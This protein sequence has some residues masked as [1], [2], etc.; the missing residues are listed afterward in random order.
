MC[1]TRTLQV[2]EPSIGAPSQYADALSP[3]VWAHAHAHLWVALGLAAAYSQRGR[4]TVHGELTGYERPSFSGSSR[5]DWPTAFLAR[6]M[7][8]P[9]ISSYAKCRC[10]LCTAWL[11]PPLLPRARPHNVNT[12][13]TP[14]SKPSQDPPRYRPAAPSCPSVS[15][16]ASA[17]VPPGRE[18]ASS[19]ARPSP[20]GPR[21]A[22]RDPRPDRRG[23]E[24][25]GLAMT[26][27]ITVA[28]TCHEAVR[29]P[30]CRSP[31]SSAS[32]KSS[33]ISLCTSSNIHV[34]RSWRTLGCRLRTPEG[35]QSSLQATSRPTPAPTPV[36][37]VHFEGGGRE[38]RSKR[39]LGGRRGAYVRHYE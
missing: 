22:P 21:R 26:R 38:S 7:A 36:A 3:G 33:G 4:S 23:P 31:Y 13:F 2:N 39:P 29:L 18:R 14:R 10:P 1:L 32:A 19:P 30:A 5:H 24:S 16:S 15:M 35:Q 27:N 20:P 34:R 28:D 17:P 8:A 25:R 37:H 12:I 6:S 11:A 9:N